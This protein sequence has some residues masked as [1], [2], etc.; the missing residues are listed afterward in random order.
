MRTIQRMD[1]N[2]DRRREIK[3]LFALRDS[4]GLTYRELS[5]HSGIP[6]G[7]LNWWAHRLRHEADDDGF[8]YAGEF[9]FDRSGGGVATGPD[10]RLLHPSG[11]VIELRGELA[12]Q[13][14]S[15]VLRDVL[16]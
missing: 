12:D 4:E 9:D 16:P 2:G 3:R 8:V 5:D 11:L 10:A 14:V 6:L 13:V 7:T 15:S 1:K